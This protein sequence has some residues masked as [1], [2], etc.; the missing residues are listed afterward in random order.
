M[1]KPFRLYYNI[2]NTILNRKEEGTLPMEWIISGYCRGQ[3]QARSILLEQDGGQ[4]YCDCD[5]PDCPYAAGCPIG[6]EIHE[7]QQEATP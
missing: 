1:D 6:S 5:Y 7:K 3:D 2:F 4:W